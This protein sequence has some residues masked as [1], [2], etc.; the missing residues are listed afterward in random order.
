M[1]LEAHS[2][3]TVMQIATPSISALL[4]KQLAAV[5]IDLEANRKVSQR[6]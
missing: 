3:S 5:R 1:D 6:F 4:L 2:T